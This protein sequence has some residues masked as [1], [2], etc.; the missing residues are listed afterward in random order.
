MNNTVPTHWVFLRGLSRETA[1]WDDFPQRCE[2]DLGWQVECI[3]LPGFG[4]QH[5]RA[6]P[7][8]IAAIVA[9]IRSRSTTQN[10]AEKRGILGLSLGGMLALHW[11][12]S[13]PQD[14]TAIITINSSSGNSPLHHRLKPS[15][16]LP[17][18]KSFSSRSIKRQE[19]AILKMV[20]NNS[21]DDNDVLAQWVKLRQ[22]NKIQKR[23][24]I[25]QLIAASR[26][27]LPSAN[28][29]THIQHGLVLSSYAD[30]M[31]SWQCSEL[32]AERY[33][34]PL[35]LHNH[36]GHDLPLDDPNW[37]LTEISRWQNA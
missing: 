24:V 5:R 1:H 14:L 7:N 16:L 11:A 15:A 4:D 20:S 36:A 28:A 22:H 25:N 35:V 6:S 33:H 29:V 13:Y 18:I 32:V 10:T 3:D 12:A 2:A 30:R 31:V 21:A 19:R 34:W 26:Y 27:R 37:I 23:N 17:V 8:N 9:D